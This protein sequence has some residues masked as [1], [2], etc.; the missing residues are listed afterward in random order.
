MTQGFLITNN[1]AA[2]KEYSGRVKTVYLE[3]AKFMDVLY[4][5]RDKIHEGY[6][7]LTHPLSGSIKPGQTPYKSIM[8][9][10]DKGELDV[11]SLKIMEDAIIVSIKQ[12][13]QRKEP[14][15]PKGVLEDF[16]LIDLDLV[17]GGNNSTC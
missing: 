11:E 2:N 14:L 4:F 13:E 17:T 10:R 5:A 9:S 8:I 7:L 15:W 1:P 16:Q 6:R 12:I 3:N